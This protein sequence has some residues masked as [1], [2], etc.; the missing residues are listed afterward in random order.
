MQIYNF[1]FNLQIKIKDFLTFTYA[2]MPSGHTALMI[3]LATIIGL[4]QG[5]HS[6]AFAICFVLAIV[7][8]N[9]ALRLR[10]YIGQQGEILNVLV[11]ELKSDDLLEKRYPHLMENIGHTFKQVLAGAILGFLVALIIFLLFW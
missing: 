1:F 10:N 11:K 8:I 9:D 3:S 4:T 6:A 2:G 5:F 7:I